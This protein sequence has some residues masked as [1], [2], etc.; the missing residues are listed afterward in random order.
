MKAASR[1][2]IAMVCTAATLYAAGVVLSHYVF[3]E[4]APQFTGDVALNQKVMFLRG[5]RPAAPVGV[6][7]GSSMALNNLD[8]DMLQSADGKPWINTGIWGVSHTEMRSFYDNVRREFP[9]REVVIVTQFFELNDHDRN[10]MKMAPGLFRQYVGGRLGWAQEFSYR[11]VVQS[12]R[13][14]LGW[15]HNEGD[16]NNIQSLL[17]SPTGAVHVHVFAGPGG[18]TRPSPFESYLGSCDHCTRS[19]SD[20]CGEVRADGKPVTFVVPPLTHASR[21]RKQSVNQLYEL[22]RTRIR[23]VGQ[24][25]GARVFDAAV[26]ADF[27]DS[28]FIDF[29][30][31][32]WQGMNA[33]TRLFLRWRQTGASSPKMAVTCTAG[34]NPILRKAG[35]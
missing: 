28:C 33:L 27:D 5:H 35:T 29:A 23:Q 21:A 34:Q 22:G 10:E 7:V 17:Y 1:Y 26:A 6:V 25:C 15:K 32:N 30:H 2:L 9:V 31:L 19:L 16:P 13:E 20:F 14:K 11:D 12:L 3:R 4:I 18:P 24:A 8:S